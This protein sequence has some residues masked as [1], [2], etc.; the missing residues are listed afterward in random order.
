MKPSP[1]DSKASTES[2]GILKSGQRQNLSGIEFIESHTDS[3]AQILI[4]T[5]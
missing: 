2:K 4:K 1:I 3:Q 5:M